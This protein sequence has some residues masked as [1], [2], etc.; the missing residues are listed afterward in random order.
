MNS[1]QETYKEKA[2]VQIWKKRNFCMTNRHENQAKRQNYDELSEAIW[3]YRTSTA[4]ILAVGKGA[5]KGVRLIL[6]KTWK[7]GLLWVPDFGKD[8]GLGECDQKLQRWWL[9][10]ERI[11]S[12]NGDGM[13]ISSNGKSNSSFMIKR[14]ER[15]LIFFLNAG[16]VVHHTRW[17]IWRQEFQGLWQVYGSYGRNTKRK[18][19]IFR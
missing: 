12:R 14:V 11:N 2:N 13:S 18:I 19:N 3:C 16:I 6:S 4:C 1:V 15:I 9:L 17:V 8:G 5:S 10:V 7:L